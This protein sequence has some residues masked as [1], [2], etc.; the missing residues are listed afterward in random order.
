MRVR[1]TSRL[2]QNRRQ[3]PER[4]EFDARVIERH[5]DQIQ[6]IRT[7]D[8]SAVSQRIYQPF[9]AELAT[10]SGRGTRRAS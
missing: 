6:R 7:Q 2:D 8:L 10:R 3:G 1:S 9:D 4:D 5:Y